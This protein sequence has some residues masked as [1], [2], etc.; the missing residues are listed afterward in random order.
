MVSIKDIASDIGVTAATVSNA[1]NGKGRVSEE[2]AA[3]IRRRADELGYRPSS[4]AVALKSGRSQVLGLVMP[5][6]TNPLFPHIAQAFSI[7]AEKLGYAILI[8]DSRGSSEEQSL[9]IRR[10]ISRGVD[11][12]L[13][14]PQ[15]GSTVPTTTTPTAIINT[16]SDPNNSASADHFGGG[17]LV[18]THIAKLG[19]K[20][21]LII[22][23]D[24]VSDVQKERVS[25]MRSAF[26]EDTKLELL[27]GD[28][29]IEQAAQK[30]KEGVS[31]IL[32]TSD[33]VAIKVHSNLARSGLSV[34]NDASLT[35]FD[36]MSFASSMH[37]PL[38]T[39]AQDVETLAQY[40]LDIITKQLEG[41]KSPHQGQTVSMNLVLR[42]STAIPNSSSK[43][44]PIS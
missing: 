3:R 8:A 41:Q 10:L 37:P 27:W 28:Q 16:S 31:A 15:R 30:V 19:H 13:V 25:G 40:V 7:A 20:N 2:L 9:A 39:V 14:V 33:I 21:I 23:A 5:D 42:N 29:G 43:K 44:E 18:G 1:L 38:T 4:A 11:G 34:P 12:L 32:T 6:L 35:G 26:A 22:G 24:S 36:D 17:A